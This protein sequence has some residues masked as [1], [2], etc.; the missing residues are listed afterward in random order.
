MRAWLRRQ[1]GTLAALNAEW[2]TDFAAWDMVHPL[3][4]DAALR[5][6]DGDFAGWADFKAWMDVAFAAAVRAGTD[7]VHAADPAARAAIEG[8]QA[9]GWAAT[10]TPGSARRWT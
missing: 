2:G 5:R 3:T 7:A 8:A 4:A 1:H 9:P 10:T 6:A